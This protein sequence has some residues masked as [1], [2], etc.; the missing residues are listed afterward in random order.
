MTEPE[1]SRLLIGLRRILEAALAAERY[2][3]GLSKEEFLQDG[4][5]RDAVCM[6]IIVIGENAAKLLEKH[7]DELESEHPDIPWKAMRG[8]RHRM[9]HGYEETDFEM[10]WETLR[11]YIPELIA[12]L[13]KKRGLAVPTPCIDAGGTDQENK[14][15]S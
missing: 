7:R 9:A 10:V 15:H 3:E 4:K 12:S 13:R 1:G 6:N 14:N 5:T 2:V 11:T 8:M